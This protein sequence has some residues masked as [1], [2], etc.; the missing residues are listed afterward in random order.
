MHV[1]HI[2]FQNVSRDAWI[3]SQQR[4]LE[5]SLESGGLV[6]AWG[7]LHRQD[8]RAVFEW[9][10]ADAVRAFM[11]ST[12]ERALADAGIVGK[13]AVL[14]LDP[15]LDLGP[16]KD[17]R[18]VAESIAWIK[19]GGTEPWLASQREWCE[20][21]ARCDGFVGGSIV[22]GRRTFVVTSFWRDDRS[23]GR[24]LDE[25]V[26]GLR[27]RTTGDEHCAR[28]TRF[29]ASLVPELS[30]V[31]DPSAAAPALSTGVEQRGA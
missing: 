27:S 29:H 4:W 26:P 25:V 14:Y 5:L 16:R 18:Y 21:M 20:A 22:R 13:S 28:L 30:F 2:A 31:L 1:K 10:S 12:H 17:A 19:E 23:H 3:T 7:A 11:E 8:G 9:E 6:S 24:Y 15:I